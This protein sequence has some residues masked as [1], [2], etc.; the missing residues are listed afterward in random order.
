M[1]KRYLMLS[2]AVAALSACGGADLDYGEVVV[3]SPT[4]TPEPDEIQYD[5][6]FDTDADLANFS[7]D[8]EQRDTE[9]D[10]DIDFHQESR[11]LL[12]KPAWGQDPNH[13][14]LDTWTGNNWDY[15][16]V[17]ANE[18]APIDLRSGTIYMSIYYPDEHL[19]SPWG[20]PPSGHNLGTQYVL[21]DTMGNKAM[22]KDMGDGDNWMDSFG[23]GNAANKFLRGTEEP[24]NGNGVWYDLKID[25]GFDVTPLDEDAGFD[26]SA[27]VSYGVRFNFAFE[28]PE[29]ADPESATFNRD[30]YPNG[31][32]P[33]QYL[34]IDNVAAFPFEGDGPLPTP[35]P[36]VPG[37]PAEFA[38]P[39]YLDEAG[40]GFSAWGGYGGTYEFSSTEFRKSGTAAI[41]AD[42]AADSY[43]A[44]QFGANDATNGVD[45]SGYSKFHFSVWV[46]FQTGDSDIMVQICGLDD[47]G[48]GD[49]DGVQVTALENEAWNDFS[50]DLSDFGGVTQVKEIRIKNYSSVAKVLHFDEIGFDLVLPDSGIPL[51]SGWTAS[52]AT[53][54]YTDA[55]VKYTP[56]ADNQQ[57]SF[58]LQ[59]PQTLN[60]A[61]VYLTLAADQ[62]YLDSTWSVQPFAQK[63]A[64]EEGAHW[65]CWIDASSLSL[66]P[67][68]FGCTLSNDK[69]DF[70]ESGAVK[71]GIQ[72]KQG[73]N[74]TATPAGS[75]TISNVRIVP[76]T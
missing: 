34:F 9:E 73:D 25:V 75:I 37:E 46:P 68:E 24:L 29:N 16:E 21:I 42:Y 32:I 1:L 23:Q 4:P 28:K 70:D 17:Y 12:V 63:T 60:G 2:C 19:E 20:S 69:L 6:T 10:P 58:D 65:G 74:G 53:I 31:N 41:A 67:Q 8:W 5:F 33:Q 15:V 38:L 40:G 49:T 66:D 55:G 14:G 39:V 30:I 48:C 52:D 27:V 36:P 43:G 26:L 57:A 13:R 62:D 64:G 18:N 76:G 51:D 56:S 59:G 54:E 7:I 35:E 3:S 47:S 72:G 50:L 44:I 11:S 61:T 45:I 71:I 22:L